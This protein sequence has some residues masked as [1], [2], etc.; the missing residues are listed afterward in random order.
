M[1]RIIYANS[2][3]YSISTVQELKV[4]IVNSWAKIDDLFI[5]IFNDSMSRRCKSVIRADGDAVNYKTKVLFLAWY[6]YR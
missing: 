6:H 1:A 4:A 3:Y 5:E 2:K